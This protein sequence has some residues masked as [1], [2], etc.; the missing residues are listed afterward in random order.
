MA[1]PLRKLRMKTPNTDCTEVEHL[2]AASPGYR[3]DSEK[4]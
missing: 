2:D 1:S 3:H 4:I